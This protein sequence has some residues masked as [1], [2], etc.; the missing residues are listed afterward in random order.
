MLL[1]PYKRI[2]K[3]DYKQEYWGLMELLS[4]V[5]NTAFSTLYNTLTRNISLS[6]NIYCIKKDVLVQVDSKGNPLTT[7]T[8][9]IDITGFKAVGMS[10]FNAVNQT[11]PTTYPTAVPFITFLQTD[12]GLQLNNIQG[13]PANNKFLLTI[14]AWG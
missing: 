12:A 14:I 8:M 10:V 2:Y 1:P 9:A 4:F 3:T 5:L 7:T 6:D 11:N 13:L